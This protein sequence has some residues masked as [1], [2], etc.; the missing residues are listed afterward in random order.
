M[1]VYLQ[2][3]KEIICLMP[4][5]YQF[6]KNGYFVQAVL[7]FTKDEFIFFNDHAPDKVIKK[8]GYMYHAKVKFNFNDYG[9]VMVEKIV[10]LQLAYVNRLR[11]ITKDGQKQ[12]VVYYYKKDEKMIK[13]FLEA[14]ANRKFDIVK[15]KIE[16]DSVLD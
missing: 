4:C 12:F 1:D 15:K 13:I 11:F 14:L 8:K 2:D 6:E 10:G 9:K 7:G 16:F 3:Q 5:L